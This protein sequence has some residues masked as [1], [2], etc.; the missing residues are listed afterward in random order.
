[1]KQHTLIPIISATLM[2]LVAL[3]ALAQTSARSAQTSGSTPE[4]SNASSLLFV[5]GTVSNPTGNR[6]ILNRSNDQIVVTTG[7]YAINLAPNEPIAV[8]GTLNPRTGQIEA[9]SITRSTGTNITLLPSGVT[10]SPP[11][12]GISELPTQ[13]IR[14]Q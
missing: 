7:Q 10:I 13:V 2:S 1:M 6:F 3:P 8:T 4:R 11:I 5:Y 12:E 9:Y 14:V